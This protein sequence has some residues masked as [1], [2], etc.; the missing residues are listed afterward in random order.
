MVTFNYRA[1]ISA[2][3]PL[4]IVCEAIYSYG[5]GQ[6]PLEILES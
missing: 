6:V 3:K 4:T 2:E 1:I 5:Y